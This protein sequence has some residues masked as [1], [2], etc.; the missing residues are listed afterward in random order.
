MLSDSGKSAAEICDRLGVT[1]TTFYNWK[2]KFQGL[3]AAGIDRLRRLEKE[4]RTLK[5]K[6]NRLCVDR[7]VLADSRLDIQTR[8]QYIALAL[9][10]HPITRTRAC[11]LFKLS[12]A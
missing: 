6:L 12:P 7:Q 1:D 11:R 2:Q 9:A 10:K 8:E 5:R 4:N 3:N